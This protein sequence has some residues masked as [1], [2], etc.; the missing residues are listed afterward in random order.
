MARERGG[1]HGKPLRLKGR[2]ISSTPA[3]AG[4][5]S[6]HFNAVATFAKGRCHFRVLCSASI[7]VCRAS[8]ARAVL[9]MSLDSDPWVAANSPIDAERLHALGAVIVYWNE[10]EKELLI[11]FGEVLGFPLQELWAIAHDLGQ[12]AIST[13]IEALARAKNFS[14]QFQ[15]AIKNTLAVYEICRQNRNQL[16]HFWFFSGVRGDGHL[17]RKSKKADYNPPVLFKSDLVDI[18]RVAEDIKALARHMAQLEAAINQT[19][20]A[21]PN[22]PM[23]NELPLPA[24]LYSPPSQTPT[25]Q[26]P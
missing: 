24:L 6:K 16:V 23:P 26:K 2:V 12:V 21:M 7:A 8:T 5:T 10:C 25:K 11:L 20:R 13:K 1:C 14:S 17:Y 4:K 3:T 19:G 22:S 18:R 15:S 9:P